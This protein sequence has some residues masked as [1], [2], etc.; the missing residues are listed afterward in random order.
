MDGVSELARDF[1]QIALVV[2]WLD[3]CRKRDLAALMDLY[4]PDAT[5]E[6]ACGGSAIHKGRTQLESYWQPRLAALS[7]AAFALEEIA[8]TPDGVVLDYLSYEGKP[9]RIRFTFT[10]EA[11]IM[12]TYCEP[13][14]KKS[15]R[16]SG[17]SGPAI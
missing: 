1:D 5:L 11:K 15:A 3:A 14:A 4:A 16:A 2:D 17:V 7:P 13:M 12:Q 8:P 9:V 6:C 10:P